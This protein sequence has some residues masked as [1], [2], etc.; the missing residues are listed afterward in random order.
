[1]PCSDLLHKSLCCYYSRTGPQHVP[2]CD[3]ET[4][5]ISHLIQYLQV[6]RLHQCW[7]L[8]LGFQA[9]QDV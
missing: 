3:D 6:K 8:S 5:L 1:M 9:G 7:L 2:D 4:L